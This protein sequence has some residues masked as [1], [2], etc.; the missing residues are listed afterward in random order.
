MKLTWSPYRLLIP[1]TDTQRKTNKEKND[2]PWRWCCCG[3]TPQSSISCIM[4]CLAKHSML[5]TQT[6]L[7]PWWKPGQFWNSTKL[8]KTS[9]P[10]RNANSTKWKL[11]E[12]IPGLFLL[13]LVTFSTPSDISEWRGQTP[14]I[15]TLLLVLHFSC[16]FVLNLLHSTSSILSSRLART[17]LLLFS[18]TLIHSF[19]AIRLTH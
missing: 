11:Q 1:A 17:V 3:L 15:R 4:S 19:P 12:A 10:L 7:L 18:G 13:I 5:P 8:T 9:R 6:W 14:W 16:F 2:I